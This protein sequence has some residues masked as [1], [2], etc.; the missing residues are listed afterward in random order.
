MEF[1]ENIPKFIALA[2]N[3]GVTYNDMCS[4]NSTKVAYKNGGIN[5]LVLYQ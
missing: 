3:H 4:V 5:L 2:P 1:N